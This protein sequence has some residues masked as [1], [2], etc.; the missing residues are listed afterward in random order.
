MYLSANTKLTS[1]RIV[2]KSVIRLQGN[3]SSDTQISVGEANDDANTQVDSDAAYDSVT[4]EK[5][6]VDY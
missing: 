2:L 1:L 3:E 6:F 5:A 4:A